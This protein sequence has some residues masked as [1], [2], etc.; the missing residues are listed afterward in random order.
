MNKEICKQM[1]ALLERDTQDYLA[2]YKSIFML[3][4][5]GHPQE[6]PEL[7]EY[8]F[9]CNLENGHADEN[10]EKIMND[11]L[12]QSCRK[13]TSQ[14]AACLS[15]RGDPKEI[16]YRDLWALL[17]SP[18]YANDNERGMALLF[19]CSNARLPYHYLGIGAGVDGE[20]FHRLTAKNI[21][22]I[23]HGCQIVL[24]KD[25]K[26]RME[27]SSLVLDLLNTIDDPMDRTVVLAQIMRFMDRKKQQ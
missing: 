12:W 9:I 22:K 15:R 4:N 5:D 23:L 24:N 7:L 18:C 16:F 20:E 6:A 11:P 8:F 14:L 1:K 13:V 3:I 21:E 19:L 2:R 25:D 27:A 10:L 17:Q 26:Q